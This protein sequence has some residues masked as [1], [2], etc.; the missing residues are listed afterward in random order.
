MNIAIGERFGGLVSLGRIPGQTG[1]FRPGFG[2]IYAFMCDCGERILRVGSKV[3][4]L[5]RCSCGCLRGG[6]STHGMSGTR[7]Y[8]LWAG[9]IQRC[10]NKTRDN[11]ERYGGRGITVCERWMLFE[12]FHGDMGDKPAGMSLDR[13]NNDG[14]Y[15]PENC[16]WATLK[17]QAANK[18]PRT[19]LSGAQK[20]GAK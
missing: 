4:R 10:T 2:A 8:K 9:M 3:S 6:K 18:R 12:N 1:G 7:I 14:D 5:R 11:Y 13:I 20:G 17:M 19:G 16:R 15:S